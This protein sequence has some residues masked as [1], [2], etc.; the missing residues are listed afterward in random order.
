MMRGSDVLLRPPTLLVFVGAQVGIGVIASLLVM[1]TRS[2]AGSGW[3][4][5]A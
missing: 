4:V 5:W 3:C 2:R 1:A